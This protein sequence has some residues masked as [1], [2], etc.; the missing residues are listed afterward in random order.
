MS[1]VL[2]RLNAL[3]HLAAGI[4]RIPCNFPKFHNE[5][6]SPLFAGVS[7]AEPE[8]VLSFLCPSPFD[9]DAPFKDSKPSS[10]VFCID[11]LKKAWHV[12]LGVD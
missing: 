10:A 9:S 1:N 11:G 4:P 3:L 2:R 5:R 7:S 6:G 12:R 8:E